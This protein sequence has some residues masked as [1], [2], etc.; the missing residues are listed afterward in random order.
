MADIT[1][2]GDKIVRCRMNKEIV[3][4][5]G[6]TMYKCSIICTDCLQNGIIIFPYYGTLNG[7]FL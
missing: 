7:I 1:T 4:P 5:L 2:E 6:S 3:V